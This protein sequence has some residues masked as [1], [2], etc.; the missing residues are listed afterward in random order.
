MQGVLHE[1]TLCPCRFNAL[2][3]CGRAGFLAKASGIA[4]K[5]GLT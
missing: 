5:N 2:L 1:L 4:I 3:E